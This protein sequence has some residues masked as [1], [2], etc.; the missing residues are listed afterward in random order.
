MA[1]GVLISIIPWYPELAQAGPYPNPLVP[2]LRGTWTWSQQVLHSLGHRKLPL[3]PRRCQAPAG[4]YEGGCGVGG[5]KRRGALRQWGG[6]LPHKD[7]G[8]PPLVPL[9]RAGAGHRCCWKGGGHSA[10]W[11]PVPVGASG[12]RTHSQ[13]PPLQ[14]S[15]TAATHGGDGDIVRS[16]AVLCHERG[17]H[18]CWSGWEAEQCHVM[19]GHSRFGT[20]LPAHQSI[21]KRGSGAWLRW[22]GGCG[23]RILPCWSCVG[24]AASAE[25]G[26]CQPGAGGGK[27]P[28]CGAAGDGGADGAQGSPP[29]VAG[30]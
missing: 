10:G 18:P 19:G 30:S 26:W 7:K 4:T 16:G 22:G 25:P 11:S 29:P 6:W 14:F 23:G 3:Q 1:M 13:A 9:R 12:G 28:G 21:G 5:R 15:A 20:A 24:A 8:P 2:C 27:G 17:P